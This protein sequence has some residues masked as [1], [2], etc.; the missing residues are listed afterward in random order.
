MNKEVTIVYNKLFEKKV[1][2]F[3]LTGTIP[4]PPV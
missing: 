3:R 2:I 1:H 4:M